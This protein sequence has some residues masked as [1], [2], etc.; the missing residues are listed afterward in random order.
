MADIRLRL[1]QLRQIAG[2]ESGQLTALHPLLLL[3][4]REACVDGLAVQL[5]QRAGGRAQLV[6]RDKGMPRAEVIRELKQDPGL[7][8]PLIV[9]ADAECD[10]KRID[11]RKIRAVIGVRQQ[12][13]VI[14][15]RL[16]RQLPVSAVEPHGELR[17]QVVHGQK[18]DEPPDAGLALEALSHLLRLFLCDPGDL[19]QAH[20]VLLEH[21]QALVAEAAD[22]LLRRPRADAL[23]G[24]GGQ[25][26]QD[27][28]R[29]LRHEAFEKLRLKLLAE[30]L[31]ARPLADDRQPLAH[32]AH[33][34]GP[35]DGDRLSLLRADLQHAVAVFGVL[36]NDREHGPLYHLRFLFHSILP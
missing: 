13:R 12:I 4:A 35:D 34:D 27:L 16:L 22:D 33:G 6:L 15:Q 5:Q 19:G 1:I 30:T 28:A 32:D 9:G 23:D 10:G 24:A 2:R 8:A 20:G 18:L 7:H 11:L 14:L 36:I 3:Q 25:K 31:V 17:R 29:R 26:S 21:G